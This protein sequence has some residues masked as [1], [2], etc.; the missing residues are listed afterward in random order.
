[1]DLD[2]GAIPAGALV[3]EPVGEQVLA[4]AALSL[5][6]DGALGLRQP[7]RHLQQLAH[8]W[9]LGDDPRERLVRHR[10]HPATSRLSAPPHSR[11]RS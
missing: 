8:G 7:G 3:V 9:R 5:D 1:M 11:S 6:E 4:G 10:A 2:E